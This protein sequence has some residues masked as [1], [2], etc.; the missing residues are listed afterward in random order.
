MQLDLRSRLN[1]T[2][3]AGEAPPSRRSG[4]LAGDAAP[5]PDPA[6]LDF[7][8]ASSGG[9]ALRALGEQR[10]QP[11][12]YSEAHV[13]ALGSAGSEWVLFEDGFDAS[14][15]RVR[16]CTVLQEQVSKS[17]AACI[18]CSAFLKDAFRD[19]PGGVCRAI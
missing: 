7:A 16:T 14:G 15:K 19:T 11:E 12:E 3:L 9:S 13:A 18:V 2:Q 10:A 17:S 5:V 1:T 4:R 8:E 6:A